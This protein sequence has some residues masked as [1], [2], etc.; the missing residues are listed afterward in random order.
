MDIF[1]VFSWGINSDFDLVSLDGKEKTGPVVLNL[2][3]LEI[4]GEM[5]G[6]MNNETHLK[7]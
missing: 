6:Q 1:W 5:A 3:W 4:A 7:Y 2:D